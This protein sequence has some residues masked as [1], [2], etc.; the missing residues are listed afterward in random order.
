MKLID[1]KP[2]DLGNTTGTGIINEAWDEYGTDMGGMGED[3]T[4]PPDVELK[5]GIIDNAVSQVLGATS[6][7]DKIDLLALAVQIMATVTLQ[8]AEQ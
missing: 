1:I 4:I 5:L 6:V 3:D 8:G 7:E 2:L